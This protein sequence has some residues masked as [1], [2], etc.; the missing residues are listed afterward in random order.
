MT[1]T[2]VS[3]NDKIRVAS[4]LHSISAIAARI[5][6]NQAVDDR[7]VELVSNLQFASAL[8]FIHPKGINR[9]TTSSFSIQIK[10]TLTGLKLVLIVPPSFPD[11]AA[12][13]LLSIIYA[14]YTDYVLKDPFYALDMPIRCSLFDKAVK[15]ILAIGSR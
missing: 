10:D 1:S 15:Q 8:A 6:P 11:A 7:Y 13:E 4:I 3:S 5:S 2:Q 12:A 9:I 14:S